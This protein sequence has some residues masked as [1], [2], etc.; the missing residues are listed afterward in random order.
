[1]R[2]VLSIPTASIHTLAAAPGARRPPVARAPHITAAAPGL[3]QPAANMSTI[4]AMV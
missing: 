4:H 3:L 1:M 2:I